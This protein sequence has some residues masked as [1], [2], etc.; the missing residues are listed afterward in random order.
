MEKCLFFT[1]PGAPKGKGR[2]RVTKTGHAFTP[3]DT[4]EYENLVR[5]YFTQTYPQHVLID[6]PVKAEITAYFPIPKSWTKKKHQQ[7]KN[8]KVFPVTK[9]DADNIAKSILD[10]LNN[11]AF[12]DDSHVIE[13]SVRKLYNHVP[14]VDTLITYDDG[15]PEETEIQKDE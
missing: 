10:S 14:R 8:G 11:I 4:A 15:K 7:W 2:P 13:L 1:V 5:L 9:P 12:T 3:K 6:G